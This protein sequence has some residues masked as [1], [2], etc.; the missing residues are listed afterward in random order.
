[1]QYETK[2]L[3]RSVYGAFDVTYHHDATFGSFFSL[4]ERTDSYRDFN[5]THNEKTFLLYSLIQY[6]TRS[7]LFKLILIKLKTDN[8]L[9]L[10]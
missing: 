2:L 3:S 10:V 8:I 7:F 9:K 1:M 5:T 6:G 4:I